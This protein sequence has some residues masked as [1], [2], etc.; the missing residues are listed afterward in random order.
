MKTEGQ[1]GIGERERGRD[2][3]RD[4]ERD[5]EIERKLEEAIKR[6][7]RI[8]RGD[9]DKDEGRYY[10]KQRELDREREKHRERDRDYDRDILR[11]GGRGRGGERSFAQSTTSAADRL[12]HPVPVINASARV[13]GIGKA[14]KKKSPVEEGEWNEK[15]LAALF[16]PDRPIMGGH[17]PPKPAI[18]SHFTTK[19]NMAHLPPR[20]SGATSAAALYGGNA[21]PKYA[22]YDVKGGQ[23]QTQ[24]DAVEWL[25]RGQAVKR[26]HDTQSGSAGE[27]SHLYGNGG[28][29]TIPDEPLKKKRRR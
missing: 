29:S 25:G 14:S 20:P 23:A 12:P 10:D 6:D 13:N 11:E 2:K 1:S 8:R 5:R 28:G 4:R 22:V 24:S 16:P 21:E 7:R 18:S 17:L 19:P 9:R 3:E 27:Y 15:E 26:W